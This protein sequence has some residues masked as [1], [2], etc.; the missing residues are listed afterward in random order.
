LHTLYLESQVSITPEF[1]EVVLLGVLVT[2]VLTIVVYRKK[3]LN[4]LLKF[5]RFV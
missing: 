4:S 1:S 3:Y 2:T 5:S